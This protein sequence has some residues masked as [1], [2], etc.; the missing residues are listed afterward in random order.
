VPRIGFEPIHPEG[1]G[2]TD[3]PDSP[4]SAARQVG[5]FFE[6]VVHRPHFFEEVK[7]D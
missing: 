3:R 4:T 2:F 6:E 7:T 5:A 1:N